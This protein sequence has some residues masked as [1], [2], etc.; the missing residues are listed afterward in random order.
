M[1][2]WPPSA[3]GFPKQHLPSPATR[4]TPTVQVITRMSHLPVVQASAAC[5]EAM[6]GEPPVRR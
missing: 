2:C 3:E 1:E 5:E 4:N 6:P